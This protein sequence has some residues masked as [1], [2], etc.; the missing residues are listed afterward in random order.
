[1]TSK[2]DKDKKE[3][4]QAQKQEQVQII[5]L[6]LIKNYIFIILSHILALIKHNEL[7]RSITNYMPFS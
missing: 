1:M 5:H 7:L 6:L 3:A 2:W 4:H